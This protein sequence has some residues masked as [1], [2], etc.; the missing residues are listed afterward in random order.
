MRTTK[1]LFSHFFDGL[2]SISFSTLIL[3]LRALEWGSS[4]IINLLT[5][6]VFWSRL[7]SNKLAEFILWSKSLVSVD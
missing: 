7:S 5:E 3:Q 2:V 6:L 4:L 1:Q